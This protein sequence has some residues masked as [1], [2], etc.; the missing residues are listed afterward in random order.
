M[1][2]RFEA[3][4]IDGVRRGAVGADS[5]LGDMI[6]TL[7]R[8][9][10]LGGHLAPLDGTEPIPDDGPGVDVGVDDLLV[11]VA[12]PD[13]SLPVHAQWHDITLT[14]GPYLVVGRMPTMPGFDPGR[15]LARP[16]GPFVLF[17]DIRLSLAAN[18]SG[19]FVDIPLAW[20]NRYDVERVESD[21]E[22]GFF[23]PGAASIVTHGYVS[24][25]TG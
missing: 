7:D 15:A 20:V 5:R 8:I 23:F 9:R 24:A 19:G 6:E 18:P 1:P 10:I 21:I 22:L 17:S 25:T 4:T 12:P 3:Y 2:M 13:A 16:T 14:V 11:V